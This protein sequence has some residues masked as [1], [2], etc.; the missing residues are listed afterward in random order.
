M[1]RAGDAGA[2]QRLARAI[3]RAHRHQARH[4]GL[5]DGELPAAPFGEFDVGD[6]VVV[7]RMGHGES[8]EAAREFGALYQAASPKAI[9]I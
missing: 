2:F 9:K 1:Q 8:L 4:F 5:G 6:G 3:F 7:E